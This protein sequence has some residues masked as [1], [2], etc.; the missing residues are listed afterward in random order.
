MYNYLLKRDIEGFYE[1]ELKNRLEFGYPPFV[2]FIKLI[3]Q[4]TN[5]ERAKKNSQNIAHLV[6][7]L[8]NEYHYSIKIIGPSPSYRKKIRNRYRYNV[9][10]KFP[11]TYGSDKINIILYKLP[12]SCLIDIDPETVL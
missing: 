9:L 12:T 8:V 7:K 11:I 3:I 1:N 6:S 10:L 4:D 5:Y 2:R